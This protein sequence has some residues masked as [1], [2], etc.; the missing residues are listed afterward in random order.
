MLPKYYP[1]Q[2][3]LV[4]SSFKFRHPTIIHEKF[5]KFLPSKDCEILICES[6]YPIYLLQSDEEMINFFIIEVEENFNMES[7]DSIFHVVLG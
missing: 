1:H 4:N 7:I 6:N 2:I 5:L 3:S